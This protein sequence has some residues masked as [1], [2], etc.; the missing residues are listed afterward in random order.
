MFKNHKT[1]IPATHCGCHESSDEDLVS[2]IRRQGSVADAASSN[3]RS[4]TDPHLT[5]QV[6]LEDGC[7][8][9]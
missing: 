1:S 7:Y 5:G 4:V 2:R 3:L 8:P 9:G 6:F